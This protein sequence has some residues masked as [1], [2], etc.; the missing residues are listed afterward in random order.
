MST[1]RRAWAVGL[2]TY[3]IRACGHG[4]RKATD[5]G[6]SCVLNT[7]PVAARF[8][9]MHRRHDGNI[10]PSAEMLL[11]AAR[12]IHSLCTTFRPLISRLTLTLHVQ[13][14]LV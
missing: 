6:I 14:K 4:S 10:A 11:A 9:T 13:P 3:A 7:F 2:R 1:H 12:I 8:L 5:G